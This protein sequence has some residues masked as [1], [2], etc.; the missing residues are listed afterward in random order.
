MLERPINY[1]LHEAQAIAGRIT[2]VDF[3]NPATGQ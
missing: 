1:G 3:V 2:T